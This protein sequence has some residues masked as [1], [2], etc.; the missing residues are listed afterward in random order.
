MKPII[1]FQLDTVYSVD[2]TFFA[3]KDFQDAYF[4]K[5]Y[6]SESNLYF[7]TKSKKTRFNIEKTTIENNSLKTTIVVGNDENQIS[8]TIPEIKI[9]E[10]I[11]QKS[12]SKIIYAK[13]QNGDLISIR[14]NDIIT[15]SN[16]DLDNEP[17]IIYIGQSFRLQERIQNHEKIIQAFSGLKEDEDI[18]FHFVNVSFAFPDLENKKLLHFNKLTL[19]KENLFG[20]NYNTLIELSER[21]LINFFRPSL[22]VKHISSAIENDAVLCKIISDYDIYKV[23]CSYDLVGISYQFISQNQRLANKTFYLDCSDKPYEYKPEH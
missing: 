21:I 20:L 2:S 22:N 14:P 15:N 12:H 11:F 19:I 18:R 16:I 3:D 17:E 23:I 1:Y 10:I 7:I 9:S 6:I 5:K 13:N 8:I 4:N